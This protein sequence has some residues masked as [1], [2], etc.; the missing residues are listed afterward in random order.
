MR[1]SRVAVLAVPILVAGALVPVALAAD[2]ATGGPDEGTYYLQSAA[3][4]LN[5]AASQNAVVQHRPKGNE[6]H[7][8]WTLRADADGYRL[9]NTDPVGRC[10]GRAGTGTAMVACP[11]PDAL[12]QVTAAGP[13]RWRVKDPAAE[14]YLS[15]PASGEALPLGGAAD[16]YLTPLTLPRT[17]LP[18]PDARTLDQVSFLTAHNA[19]ANGVDG[20]FAPPILNLFPNQNR[21]LNQQLADG[22]RGFMFDIYQ[23]RDGAILCHQSCF[24]V[25]RPVALSVD[26]QRIVD[27][28]RANPSE[29]VTVFLEDYTAP[30][31]L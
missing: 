13:G 15:T 24:L 10:L 19:F 22:V 2:A 6:D 29:F 25:S 16:W 4:G 3:T 28:L 17:A 21:G 9:E 18:A 8:Q 30:D 1:V 5:A 26:L 20:G 14:R 11:G 7:Q 31:V 23:T 12:W 27:F